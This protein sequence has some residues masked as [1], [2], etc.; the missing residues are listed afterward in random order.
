MSYAPF[1]HRLPAPTVAVA[2]LLIFRRR[3]LK[4]LDREVRGHATHEKLPTLRLG[5]LLGACSKIAV[6]F[7]K[8]FQMSH[9][10][11]KSKNEVQNEGEGKVTK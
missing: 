9:F 1:N 10:E 6:L 5:V 2:K 7:V 11:A 8:C 3:D 4:L